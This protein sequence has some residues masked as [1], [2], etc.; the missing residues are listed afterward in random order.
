MHHG[1][2]DNAPFQRSACTICAVDVHHSGRRIH[3]CGKCVGYCA[4][5]GHEG[6][7][8]S[9]L[10][11]Q[12]NCL[13]KEC[14]HYVKREKSAFVNQFEPLGQW[15]RDVPEM[16]IRK[17]RSLTAELEGMEFVQVNSSR[18]GVCE[19]SYVSITN[20][21]KMND[22]ATAISESTGCQIILKQLQYPFELAATIIMKKNLVSAS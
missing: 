17:A 19:L 21:Y 14:Y 20:E 1:C 8:T 22:I 13:E 3:G 5:K 10:R 6:Y 18:I 4:Y 2:G 15:F 9:E 16:V 12:H 7:L 11:K